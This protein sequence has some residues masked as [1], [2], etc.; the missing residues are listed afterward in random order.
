MIYGVNLS[1]LTWRDFGTNRR[2]ITDCNIRAALLLDPVVCPT[3]EYKFLMDF[4]RLLIE[5]TANDLQIWH[6]LYQQKKYKAAYR[7]LDEVYSRKINS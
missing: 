6:D 1:H 5:M 2:G 7:F 3:H 4:Q